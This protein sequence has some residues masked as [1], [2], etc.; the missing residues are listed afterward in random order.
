MC[1]PWEV[2][3]HCFLKNTTIAHTQKDW[4]CIITV[5]SHYNILSNYLSWWDEDYAM[6]HIC[7]VYKGLTNITNENLQVWGLLLSIRHY[8]VHSCSHLLCLADHRPP[9]ETEI[10]WA[11]MSWPEVYFFCHLYFPYLSRP[12]L[13]SN[14]PQSRTCGIWEKH[15]LQSF[16]GPSFQVTR[17]TYGRTNNWAG[18]GMT[19]WTTR[20]KT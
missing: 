16:L 17:A 2:L 9:E 4:I 11:Q 10:I 18:D 20:S 3:L 15:S 6:Q 8:S 19:V 1:W 14:H 13:F 5:L 12:L 7:G